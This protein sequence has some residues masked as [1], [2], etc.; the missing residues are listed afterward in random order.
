M[1]FGVLGPLR[2]NGG[3]V[4]LAAKPRIVLA[5]LLLHANHVVPVDALIDAVWDDEPPSSARI[6]LQGY[7]K[8]LRRSIEAPAD[9]RVVTRSAGYLIRVGPG[10]LDLDRFAGLWDRARS[11]AGRGDWHTAAGQVSEALALW[12]GA[13][14]ADVSSAVLRRTEVPRL[15]EQRWQAVELRVA[16]DLRLDRHAELVAEL[17]QLT[18]GEPLREGLHGQLMLA[19]CRCG[20]QAEALAVFRAVDRRLRDE[21]GI[22]AG[23]ALRELHQRILAADPALTGDP[24]PPAGAPPTRPVAAA[25]VAGAWRLCRRSCPRTRLISPGGR[26]R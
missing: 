9:K 25:A 5:A 20:R 13:P 8:L 1:E 12:R 15:A 22:C 2:V 3:D 14:L 4:A 24:P 26:S 23:P 21:L 19:L 17:H 6:T 16:A 10:E 18:G 7:V 11:A